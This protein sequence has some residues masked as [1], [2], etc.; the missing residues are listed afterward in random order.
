M[1]PV[2]RQLDV[3]ADAVE[4]ARRLSDRAGVALLTE[5]FGGGRAFVACDPSAQAELL[6]PEPGLGLD[7]D[8]GPLGTLPRWIGVLPYE[9]RRS[10]ERPGLTRSVDRRPPPHLPKPRL[11]A[12]DTVFD[13]SAYEQ[14]IIDESRERLDEIRK[15]HLDA[16]VPFQLVV[17]IGRPAEEIL[18]V[19]EE[20]QADVIF[21]ATHG[22]SGLANVVYGS[23][24]QRVVR[25]AT[26]PVLSIRM[27]K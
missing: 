5:G 6:D 26:C 8:A 1:P 25:R 20:E 22:R 24:A 27:C 19:A 17:R 9:C 18:A 2:A 21:V 14:Q 23:V 15:E 4:L 16:D 10:L 11:D 7:P 13:V 12:S 3:P